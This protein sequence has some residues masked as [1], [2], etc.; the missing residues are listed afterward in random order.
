MRQTQPTSTIGGYEDIS[1]KI[2]IYVLSA[3][4][5]DENAPAMPAVFGDEAEAWAKDDAVIRA[6]WDRIMDPNDDGPYPGDPDAAQH[7]IHQAHGA[8]WS[9][10][11]LTQPTS[12]RKA[13]K[14]AAF[15]ISVETGAPSKIGRTRHCCLGAVRARRTSWRRQRCYTAEF[16]S[17]R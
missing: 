5:A 1:M 13:P 2:T 16:R 15:L 11:E 9:R 17:G 10:W 12:R 14:E 3:V 7:G 6:E 8:E 4:L